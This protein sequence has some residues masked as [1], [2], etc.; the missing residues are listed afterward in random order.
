MDNSRLK[1]RAWQD[2]QMIY[3]TGALANIHRFFRVISVEAIKMQYT[4]L[5]DRTGKD[6]L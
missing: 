4:G 6:C 3:P 2:N 5:N 1:F